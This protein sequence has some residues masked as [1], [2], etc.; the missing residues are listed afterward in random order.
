M[1]VQEIDLGSVVGPQGPQGPEGPQGPTGATGPQGPQGEK[2]ERGEQGPQG[3]PGEMAEAPSIGS[4]G[5][6]YIGSRD[7]GIMADVSRA[8]S[9]KTVNSLETTEPGFVLD[10]RQGKVLKDEIDEL[11]GKISSPYNLANCTF[12]KINKV[13]NGSGSSRQ[14]FTLSKLNSIFDVSADRQ[15]Y[16]LFLWNG[17]GTNEVHIDGA[18][19][20]PNNTTFY[21]TLD[22]TYTGSIRIRGIVIYNPS[23]D[24]DIT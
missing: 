10:A 19:Y 17:D 14:L 18:T 7:T 16:D 24:G 13:V 20:T 15:D 12:R 11:N 22:R 9:N 21:A 1:A 6:W 2:G 23:T 4:N 8:L 5:N 3:I